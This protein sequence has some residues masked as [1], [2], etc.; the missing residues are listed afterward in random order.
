MIADGNVMAAPN[1]G[2]FPGSVAP[3]TERVT[4]TITL[5]GSLTSLIEG[6]SIF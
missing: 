4:K 2:V 3:E 5:D 6:Q 1:A